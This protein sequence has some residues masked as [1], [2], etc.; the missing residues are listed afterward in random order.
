MR[1]GRKRVQG[2]KE[3]TVAPSLAASTFTGRGASAD[4]GDLGDGAEAR[5]LE[6]ASD[7][8]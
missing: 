1:V 3:A 2:G 6:S 8:T 7:L 4:G 5:S